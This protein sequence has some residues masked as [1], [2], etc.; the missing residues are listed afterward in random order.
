M[1]HIA[2][3][4]TAV[5]RK[6]GTLFF[7]GGC[8]RTSEDAQQ[9]GL[10]M[11]WS[12]SRTSLQLLLVCCRHSSSCPCDWGSDSFHYFCNGSCGWMPAGNCVQVLKLLKGTQDYGSLQSEPLF[13]FH[14][15]T[16][17]MDE[18]TAG[19]MTSTQQLSQCLE[20]HTWKTVLC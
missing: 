15:V 5:S 19:S 10:H 18:L 16:S 8:F 12:L 20:S 17:V 13:G 14:T 7:L 1:L 6:D 2:R 3:S 11:H 9:K 4:N